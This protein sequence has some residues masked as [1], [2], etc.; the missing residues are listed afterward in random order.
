MRSKEHDDS[1]IFFSIAE[2]F[3]DQVIHH[4]VIIFFSNIHSLRSAIK[5]QVSTMNNKNFSQKYL[6]TIPY[7][8]SPRWCYLQRFKSKLFDPIFVYLY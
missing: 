1:L 5:C 6:Q 7:L 3:F 4:F 8:N 2:L